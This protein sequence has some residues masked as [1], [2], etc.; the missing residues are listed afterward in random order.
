MAILEA[1]E[2]EPEPPTQAQ[3]ML[4]AA[5]RVLDTNPRAWALAIHSDNITKQQLKTRLIA[6]AKMLLRQQAAN[7]LKK[8]EALEDI[9]DNTT[10]GEIKAAL[11][12]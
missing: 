1:Q 3:L 2:G 5:T 10:W 11:E 7:Q 4:D 9:D 8:L 6:D 12:E